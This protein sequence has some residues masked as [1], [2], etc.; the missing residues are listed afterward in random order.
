M[1]NFVEIDGVATQS[2]APAERDEARKAFDRAFETYR[3]I[4]SE[5]PEGS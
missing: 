1:S 4:A 3:R 2:I 5:A